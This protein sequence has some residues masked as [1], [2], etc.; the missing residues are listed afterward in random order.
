MTLPM[1]INP[2]AGGGACGERAQAAISKLASRGIEIQPHR[3]T[4]PGHATELARRLQASGHDVLLCA[5]GDGT[6]YEVVNGLFTPPSGRPTPRLGMLPLGTGNSFLKDFQIE[7]EARAIDAVAD[8]RVRPVDVVK[9]DLDSGVLHY[10][11]LLSIGF[12]S[13]VGATTN[14]WFKSLGAAGYAVATVLEVARLRARRFPI[15]LDGGP[16]DERPADFL[17][18]NN[19]RCTGGNMIMAPD[20]DPS[21]GQLDVI[22]V[23]DLGRVSLL[24]TF[25]KIYEGKHLEHPSNESARAAHVRLRLEGPVDLMVDG[26]IVRARLDALTVLPGALEIFA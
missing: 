2:A 11:N 5:G 26:E 9:A 3:T 16:F 6:A 21:D 12:T 22:R 17:S 19:S 13:D 20:A 4:R 18:F 25:P 23:G 14:R 10:I 15:S 8:G 7:T 24:R 1:I